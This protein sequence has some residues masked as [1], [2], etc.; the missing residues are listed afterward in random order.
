M[1]PLF[2]KKINS[3]FKKNKKI[4]EKSYIILFE[5]IIIRSIGKNK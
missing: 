5:D 3:F 1:I 4:F 2:F